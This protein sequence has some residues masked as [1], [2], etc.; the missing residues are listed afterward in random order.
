MSTPPALTFDE[1]AVHQ[2]VCPTG[3]FCPVARLW[4]TGY[5][6][7]SLSYVF[8]EYNN[9]FYHKFKFKHFLSS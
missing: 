5:R 8:Y 3:V 9:H 6:W 7:I 1:E 4:Q 2:G